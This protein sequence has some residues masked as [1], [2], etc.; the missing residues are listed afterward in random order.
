V[1]F[2]F[3]LRYFFFS[4][5]I[6]HINIYIYISKNVYFFIHASIYTKFKTHFKIIY[7]TTLWWLQ[8]NISLIITYISLTH[9][10]SYYAIYIFHLYKMK[11]EYKQKFLICTHTQNFNIFFLRQNKYKCG[12]N[13]IFIAFFMK[14]HAHK[15]INSWGRKYTL[16]VNIKPILPAVSLIFC[17]KKNF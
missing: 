12:V 1:S 11:C 3:Y 13:N 5:F 4:F 6:K 2:V 15:L 9:T 17:E 16:C 7:L 14:T 10:H 8:V